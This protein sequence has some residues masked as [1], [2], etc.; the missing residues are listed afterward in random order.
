[1][2]FLFVFQDYAAQARNL[3]DELLISDVRVIVARKG[4]VVPNEKEIDLLKRYPNAEAAACQLD[5]KYR[6]N[7]EPYVTFTIAPMKFRFHDQQLREWLV[8][9]E[10]L[11]VVVHSPSQAF[12]AA[13]R[14]SKLLILHSD[15][16]KTAD[17]LDETRWRFASAGADLLKQYAS[18]V[19]LGPFRE[20]DSRHG[21]SFAAHGQVGHQYKLGIG[22]QTLSIY[23]EWHLKAGDKTTPE[24]AA[25][26]YFNV[27]DAGAV[28]VVLVAHVGPHLADGSYRVDFG[29]LDPDGQ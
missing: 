5:R 6:K 15:A 16:L 13:Q 19:D 3:L 11:A 18:G 4:E 20:W 26:I 2:R 8:P 1:M 12:E 28:R 22:G 24:R 17:Q 10:H 27:V 9:T 7:V 29:N 23:S 14:S 25:R 21:V